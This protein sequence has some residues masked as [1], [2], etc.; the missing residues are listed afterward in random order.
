MELQ[1]NAAVARTD[2]APV[3]SKKS[4]FCINNNMKIC[5]N[6]NRNISKSNYLRHLV[7]CQSGR[8]FVKLQKCPYCELPFENVKSTIKFIIYFW[9]FKKKKS[10]QLINI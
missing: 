8:T 6:C 9:N 7:A 3:F 1:F 2:Q 10:L 5:E 4:Y